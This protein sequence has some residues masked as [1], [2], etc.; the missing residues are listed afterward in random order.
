MSLPKPPAAA[1]A[2][3]LLRVPDAAIYRVEGDVLT[4]INSGAVTFFSVTL[5]PPQSSDSSPTNVAAPEFVFGICNGQKVPLVKDVPLRKVQ[6]RLYVYEM[7]GHHWGLQL[8]EASNADF[9]AFE[10]LLQQY[11]SFRKAER[12]EAVKAATAFLPVWRDR[13]MVGTGK[14]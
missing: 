3:V 5:P 6:P 7:P 8:G 10:D 11:S 13:G 1:H 4:P 9:E 12:Y 2:I 14:I